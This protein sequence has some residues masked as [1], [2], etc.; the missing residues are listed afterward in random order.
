[1]K[2]KTVEKRYEDV[3]AMPQKP[4]QK[5]MRQFGV[6]RPILKVAC[7]FLLLFSRFSYKKIGMEKLG[8]D[9]PCLVLMNHSSFIDLEIVAFLLADREYHI[10]TT[11]DGFVGKAWLMRLLGCIPTKKFIND[12]ALVRDMRYTTK[13]LNASVVMY[14]E[15]SYSFDGTATP[16]PESLAKCLKL[17]NVPVVMIRT[18][19]AFIRDPLYNGLQVRKAKVSAT[20]EYILSPEDIKTKSVDELNAILAKQFDF[21]NFRSQQE[22]GIKIKEKFRADGLHRVLYKCPHCQTEGKMKGKGITI[23]C[24][25]CGKTYELTEYG[26]LKALN[27]DTMFDHIPDW[28]AWERECVRKELEN[29]TYRLDIPVDIYMLVNTKCVYKV[30]EGQLVHTIEGFYLNGC[31]GKIDYRLK[32]Q[33]SYSLYSDFFWYEIGDMISIGDE[34]IQYYCFPK[35]Q[36]NIAAKTRLAAEELHKLTKLT[37]M[38]E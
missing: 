6:L 23:T 29:E 17:L 30:G 12:V 36:E 20:M 8:K 10:V 15:A 14:P 25:H 7:W 19:G 33:A 27:G 13:E 18:D 22:Q 28:Y 11:L 16:L 5:P 21:D 32:P 1:M 37:K 35:N 9:E 31:D 24:E 38:K 3:L 26:F 4:H 2:I 34:K